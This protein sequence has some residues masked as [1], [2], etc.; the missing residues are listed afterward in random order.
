MFGPWIPLSPAWPCVTLTH[1]YPCPLHGHVLHLPMDT[2]VPCTAMCYTYPWIPLS[3][4]WP[5][6]TLTHGYPCPLHSHVLHLPMDTP[7]PCTA[8]CYT[9]PW[10]PLSP[11]QLALKFAVVGSNRYRGRVGSHNT[12]LHDMLHSDLRESDQTATSNHSL[13]KYIFMIY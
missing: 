6:V 8:M 13:V 5:C 2:P 7:V 11:A 1:G 3:P 10:I 9:Y 4:A 12:D